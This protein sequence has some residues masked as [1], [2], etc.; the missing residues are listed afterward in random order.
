MV[1]VA[2]GVGK[3]ADAV[4]VNLRTT[5][6]SE[7]TPHESPMAWISTSY[8]C[9]AVNVIA[10][11]V[12]GAEISSSTFSTLP[13]VL[14]YRV[15]AY[16]VVGQLPLTPEPPGAHE[17]VAPVPAAL[18]T[19]LRLMGVLGLVLGVA[20]GVVVALADGSGVLVAV[21]VGAGVLVGSG[22][23]VDAVAVI[24]RRAGSSE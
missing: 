16:L 17:T 14:L 10:L 3:V 23:V 13:S 1:T 19:T 8:S 7:Y 20:V 2:V 24:V 18:T 22:K 12:V 5:G 11:V 21:A 15:K 6:L 9:P 4:A